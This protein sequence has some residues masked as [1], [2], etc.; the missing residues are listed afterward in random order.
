MLWG[1]AA[2]VLVFRVNVI[3]DFGFWAKVE[4]EDYRAH[5]KQLGAGS[6]IHFLDVPEAVL[7]E[8]L[9]IRNTHPSHGEV[10]IPEAKL[11]AWME[12]IQPPEPDELE[13]RA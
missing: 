1:I 12:I 2:P 7:L 4:R 3:L 9:A 6:Q 11:K 13:A 5:A 8:R 10:Y